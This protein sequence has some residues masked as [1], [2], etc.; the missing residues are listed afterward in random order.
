M[1]ALKGP[2]GP[3]PQDMLA[4]LTSCD[5]FSGGDTDVWRANPLGLDPYSTSKTQEEPNRDKEG[6][7]WIYKVTKTGSTPH[8]EDIRPSLMIDSYCKSEDSEQPQD[9]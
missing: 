7:M 5:L 2:H 8:R 1:L 3:S 4:L 6:R 9:R